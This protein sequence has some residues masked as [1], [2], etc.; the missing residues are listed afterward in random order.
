MKKVMLFGSNGFVAK[1]FFER[2]QEKYDFLKV[3]RED[4][5]FLEDKGSKLQLQLRSPGYDAVIFLQGIN[6]QYGVE[7]IT[8]SQFSDMMKVNIFSPIDILRSITPWLNQGASIIFM[9]S[10][11]SKKGSYDPSYAVAKSGMEGMKQSLANAYPFL[12]FNSVS[13]GLIENSPVHTGMTA[14]FVDNHRSK[15]GGRLV[16]ADDACMAIEFLIECESVN[17]QDLAVD[18]GYRV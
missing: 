16:G 8:E 13:M 15:M 1:R 10:I 14:D 11:A 2:N 9:S 12:R 6:P 18:R 3:P 7:R 5:D 4:F 17:R